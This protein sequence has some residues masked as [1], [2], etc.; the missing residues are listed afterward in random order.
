MMHLKAQ[1]LTRRY[2]SG[3]SLRAIAITLGHVETN[4]AFRW[5]TNVQNQKARF[6]FGTDCLYCGLNGHDVPQCHHFLSRY[7]SKHGH[8]YRREAASSSGT[9]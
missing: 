1:V 3:E 9:M 4:G 6:K 8:D 7:K 5:E 2:V